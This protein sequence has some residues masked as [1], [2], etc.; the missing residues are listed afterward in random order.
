MQEIAWPGGPKVN[1]EAL[2]RVLARLKAQGWAVATQ[3]L[4]SEPDPRLDQGPRQTRHLVPSSAEEVAALPLDAFA[5]QSLMLRVW[6]QI[7]DGEI[8][9]VSGE[10]QVRILQGRGIPREEIYTAR[11]LADLLEL[12]GRDP[13][14][15][16][17]VLEAK[18]LFGGSLRLE[19][20]GT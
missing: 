16:S 1:E 17:F 20:A 7:L 12:F 10:A 9:F 6:A 19:E 14:K 15:A 2:K 5:G 18:R 13:E 4:P 3:D 8:W 11:E